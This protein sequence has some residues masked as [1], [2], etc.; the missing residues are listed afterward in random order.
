M[1]VRCEAGEYGLEVRVR[2][3]SSIENTTNPEATITR[4]RVYVDGVLLDDSGPIA[5]RIYV[6]EA[7]FRG[8]SGHLH[9]VQL[10]IETRAAPQ[11]GDFIQFAQCPP[12]PETPRA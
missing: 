2:Y 11:P 10:R 3:G 7:T 5:D 8:A 12:A 6:R 1:S 4:T 9:T